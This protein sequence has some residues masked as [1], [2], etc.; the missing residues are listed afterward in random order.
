MSQP[1]PIPRIVK[2]DGQVVPYDRERITTAI[3]KAAA[4]LGGTDRQR[5]ECLAAEVECAL[6]AACDEGVTPSVEE[7]QDIVERVLIHHGHTRTA[8]AFII[9]RHERAQARARSN[10]KVRFG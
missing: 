6:V 8:R 1:G 3:F 7:I 9:Y 4:S 10:G 5:A 2:R